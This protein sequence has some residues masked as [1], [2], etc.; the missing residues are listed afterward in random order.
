MKAFLL[1]TMLAALM[2]ISLG[3]LG[4]QRL[5]AQTCVPFPSG[6]VP[7]GMIDYLSGPNAQGDR[8][9]VGERAGRQVILEQI[10]LPSF[11]NQKFCGS[12][13]IAPGFF[14]E[15]YSRHRRRSSQSSWRQFGSLAASLSH[16]QCTLSHSAWETV[17]W[18]FAK[19][20]RSDYAHQTLWSR[21]AD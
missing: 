18:T 1:R 4:L 10:P 2:A 21:H 7:F 3:T 16:P 19:T 5:L 20:N 6:V 17:R 13:E 9:V 8:L 15:A 14:V 12:V 11:A